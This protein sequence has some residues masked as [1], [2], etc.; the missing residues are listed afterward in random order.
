MLAELERVLSRILLSA[1]PA[2]ELDSLDRET[3]SAETQ[4][5]LAHVDSDGLRIAGLLV[6][7]LR[8]ERLMNGSH[9]A[10]T[11]FERDPAGFAAAF[12]R[13]HTATP[14]AATCPVLEAETFAAWVET[15]DTGD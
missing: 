3:L 9:L 4:S 7:K 12:R 8:F 14:P 5:A 13:Y 10:G 15:S 11:W 2:A 1:D 6:A